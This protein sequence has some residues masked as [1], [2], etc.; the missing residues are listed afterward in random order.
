MNKIIWLTGH[1]GSGKT[2]IARIL[3]KEINAIFLDGDK[4]RESISLGTGFSKE[5]RTEHNL[6]VSRLAKVLSEQTNVIVSVIAP[7]KKVRERIDK[8]I[9]PIWVH[10]KRQVPEREGHFYEVSEDYFS[11][12]NDKYSVNE[13]VQKIVKYLGMKK[14]YSLFIGRWQP[15]HSGHLSLLNEVKKNILIGIRNTN[16]DKDNPYSVKERIDMIR[17]KLPNAEIVVIPDIDEVVYGRKVGYGIREIRL[18][19]DIEK[20][21][22]T[23]IRSK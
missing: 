19:K 9:S 21:S 22:A 6:R 16:I 14:K 12:D 2:T 3:A 8:M 15:L 11:I 4:M 7:I 13:N 17:K 5:D 20:I 18:D 1:S 23:E 10:V